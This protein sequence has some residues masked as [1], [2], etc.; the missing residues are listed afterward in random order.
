MPYKKIERK[1]KTRPVRVLFDKKTG[2]YI[3]KNRKKIPIKT[4]GIV[5]IGKLQK[6]ILKQITD[7]PNL[8]IVRAKKE[9]KVFIEDI[10][11]KIPIN[12]NLIKYDLKKTAKYLAG[13]RDKG[14]ITEAQKD[15][16][17]RDKMIPKM[18]TYNPDLATEILKANAVQSLDNLQP[19]ILRDFNK[20]EKHIEVEMNKKI[21]KRL[22]ELSTKV[23]EDMTKGI[24][25]EAQDAISRNRRSDRSDR[26]FVDEGDDEGDDD[27]SLRSLD[28][29]DMVEDILIRNKRKDLKGRVNKAVVEE[30]N[31]DDEKELI[32][33]EVAALEKKNIERLKRLK[34]EKVIVIPEDDEQ[35]KKELDASRPMGREEQPEEP[36]GPPQGEAVDLGGEEPKEPPEEPPEEPE[37]V[38][39]IEN[40]DPYALPDESN[41]DPLGHSNQIGSGKDLP[42]TYNQ[43][44]DNFL[45][46]HKGYLGCISRDEI[47]SLKRLR[48]SDNIGFVLNLSP[49]DKTKANKLNLDP[50]GSHWVAVFISPDS[51]EYFDPLADECPMDV[52]G[53][54]SAL[55]NKWKICCLLKLKQNNIKH[56]AEHTASCGWFCIKFLASRFQNIA[57][58][59]ITN[60]DKSVK[61]EKDLK[62]TFKKYI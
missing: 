23:I 13:L 42:F 32:E 51:C 14:I 41:I 45:S 8:P 38:K 40:N 47:S 4:K 28:T 7:N 43:D 5:D 22:K 11:K 6:V 54:L 19:G 57:F 34:G 17:Y 2:F 20:Y 61:S 33:L 48:N 59:T 24:I 27:G 62:K 52:L 15:V 56:Q 44:I 10:Y 35:D 1:G 53:D 60:Y 31:T 46:H 9:P 12:E 21:D 39:D 30:L 36:E 50:K 58:K 25:N 37:N 49:K 29:V 16:L 26:S 55:I 18:L 3:I